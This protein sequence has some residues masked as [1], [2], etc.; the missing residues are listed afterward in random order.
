MLT[1]ILVN[2][3]YQAPPWDQPRMSREENEQVEKKYGNPKLNVG[4]VPTLCHKCWEISSRNRIHNYKS[5][6]IKRFIGNLGRGNSGY[7]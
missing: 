5:Q 1:G 2:A 4:N 3:C 6:A 7:L